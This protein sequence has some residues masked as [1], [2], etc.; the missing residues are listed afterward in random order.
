MDYDKVQEKERK[1]FETALK[2]VKSQ[3]KCQI[4]ILMQNKCQNNVHVEKS[5][6]STFFSPLL[7]G[8]FT[9]LALPFVS[10]GEKKKVKDTHEKYRQHKRIIRQ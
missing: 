10:F 7:L 1:H 3:K 6:S 9:R 4:K 5:N 2:K 8:L